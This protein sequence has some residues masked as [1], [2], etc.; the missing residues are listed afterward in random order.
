MEINLIQ[1]LL[2]ASELKK[3]YDIKLK[4]GSVVVGTV[5]FEKKQII[6]NEITIALT[7]ICDVCLHEDND[8]L[9]RLDE[10]LN[11]RIFVKVKDCE[12]IQTG[13]L[14]DVDINEIQLITSEEQITIPVSNIE[15]VSDTEIFV[16]K[17]HN[18]QNDEKEFTSE[19]EEGI[20]KYPY[21][22][23]EENLYLQEFISDEIK[24]SCIDSFEAH[25]YGKAL[26]IL[27]NCNVSE[28][29]ADAID[30]LTDYLKGVV[31]RFE[32]KGSI[33]KEEFGYCYQGGL[34]AVIEQNVDKALAF[35]RKEIEP[36][37]EHGAMAISG[38]LN[39]VIRI[40]SKELMHEVALDLERFV[41][42]IEAINGSQ[43]QAQAYRLILTIL[44]QVEDW[45][46]FNSCLIQFVGSLSTGGHIV[47]ANNAQYKYARILIENS[48]FD[49]AEYHLA[50][51]LNAGDIERALLM[52]MHCLYCHYGESG[53]DENI[54]KYLN[55]ESVNLIWNRIKENHFNGY[56]LAKEKMQF[57]EAL[58][59]NC[60]NNENVLSKNSLDNIESN[61]DE[62]H[63]NLS[64]AVAAY[65]N[66]EMEDEWEETF[67]NYRKS[68]QIPA[69]KR[70]FKNKSSQYPNNDYLKLINRRIELWQAQYGSY[71]SIGNPSS[72][73]EKGM[74]AW[75][76]EKSNNE[77]SSLFMSSI[78][79]RGG[80]SITA[81]LTFM[82]FSAVEY[83]FDKALGNLPILR[84]LVREMEKKVKIT[85]YEKIYSFAVLDKDNGEA[86]SALNLLQGLYYSKSQ[87]GK[88]EYRLAGIYYS[89]EKWAK[90]K[91]H[92]EKA[93]QYS[94]NVDN[95]SRMIE[96]C[97]DCLAG[98][99][100]KAFIFEG[101][102]ASKVDVK[103]IE[104]ELQKYFDK[105]QYDEA[106]KYIKR[107]YESATD[108][109][110]IL[111]LKDSVEK[112]VDNISKY[113]SGFPKKSD[114]ASKAW[115]AW[116]LEE[117]YSKAEIYFRK[118]MDTK[119]AK[120]LSSLFDLSEMLMHIRGN[121]AGISCLKQEEKYVVTLEKTKQ[122]SFYEKMN[123]MLQK[124]DDYDEKKE[125]LE[126]LLDAYQAQKNTEKIAYT[127]YRLGIVAF[128]NED[129]NLSISFF[130]DAI[131]NEYKATLLCYQ[132]IVSAYVKDGRE[133]D[134]L[135]FVEGMLENEKILKDGNLSTFLQQTIEKL[136]SSMTTSEQDDSI[137]EEEV[138]LDFLFEPNDKLILYL[139][140]NQ[141]IKQQIDSDNG[142]P[143][144]K[145]QMYKR[146]INELKGTLLATNFHKL[147]IMENEI[148]GQ[149]PYFYSGLDWCVKLYARDAYSKRNYD[150]SVLWN[151]YMLGNAQNNSKDAEMAKE[152]SRNILKCALKDVVIK[153][154]IEVSDLISRILA[155]ENENAEYAFKLLVFTISKSFYLNNLQ[156]GEF[157]KIIEK[158]EN[159][160]FG[161][162]IARFINVPNREQIDG[163]SL[164]KYIQ[165]R[166]SSDTNYTQMLV[167]KFRSSKSFNEEYVDEL[168]KMREM[169]FVFEE[170]VNYLND[171]IQVYE[172]A[173]EIYEYPDYD[174]RIATIRT[175]QDQIYSVSNRIDDKPTY[176][177]IYYLGD[178]LDA[179]LSLLSSVSD[180]TMQE[181]APELFIT[182]PITEVENID[183]QNTISITVTNRENAAIA[184]SLF[185]SLYDSEGNSLIDNGSVELAPYLKGGASKSIELDFPTQT[186]DTFSVRVKVQY[187]NHK[188]ELC[189]CEQDESISTVSSTYEEIVGNPYVDGKALDPQKNRNVFMGRDALLEELSSSLVDDSGQ[190]VIIYGQ[191]RCGKTSIANFLKDKIKQEFMIIDFSVGSVLSASQLYNNVRT[192]F[193]LEILKTTKNSEM[194]EAEKQELL[195]LY[196]E[197]ST[198]KVPDGEAFI[199]MMRI[200]YGQYCLMHDQE[201]LII[202]DEFTH[203]YRL[204]QKGGNDRSEVT[205]FM[206]TWKK[207]SEEKLFKSLLIG[208][209]TMPYIMAAYPNQLAITDPRRVDRLDDES[210]KQ[211]IESPI[212]LSNGNTRYMEKSVE[213]I[214][215]WFYGQPYYI[216]VYC[217]KMVEHMKATH[218]NYVTNA[219]AEKV[220]NDMLMSSTISFFDNL[221][222]AGD[223]EMNSEDELKNLPTYKLLCNI[224]LLTKNSE[225]ANIA[226]IEI[227]DK[228]KLIEDLI[229]RSVIERRKGKCRIYIN[230]FKEWLN[231]Y[232]RE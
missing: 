214:A 172:K 63:S 231:I 86:M 140:N 190:C 68:G 83:G 101:E 196:S 54:S 107:V 5:Q 60:V 123:I 18:L 219:M 169:I 124:S 141:L 87:L 201:L 70:F 117:D 166:V 10:L 155:A 82:D 62:I 49:Y 153:E 163:S 200:I 41:P 76:V 189:V 188:D 90:A 199:E 139:L 30:K 195:S 105:C 7:D 65:I 147:A 225:W 222:N 85:F 133:E 208:Q 228:E 91:E 134:A 181:L 71:K 98:K 143:K 16:E 170:D 142:E 97:D 9:S 47:A 198:L 161:E 94:Y 173:L 180:T 154:D 33:Y 138:V 20:S 42:K 25:E 146:R 144:E 121:S 157:K 21:G 217:K 209:D 204:Y 207:G 174:N 210:V 100:P 12:D 149:T 192:R 35:Y 179:T 221:I 99:T 159:K 81:L 8:I 165:N 156:E 96:Y 22:G 220:K 227:K 151:I 11:E 27:L 128:G 58:V 52:M 176:F 202:I 72:D 126:R 95:V 19:V 84:P 15:Y 28:E 135:K 150:T 112:T 152:Y 122:I 191:K 89:Q 215:N 109:E 46:G 162:Q 186:S 26:E 115:R 232:G 184:T 216:S 36:W 212:L 205:A 132:Y 175:V 118:E 194:T 229:N 3:T 39:A 73:Y 197:I 2:K 92:L 14:F 55:N 102:G 183:N 23:F 160:M 56:M 131:K 230:F 75:F 168:R 211:L 79:S 125:C 37:G 74:Y 77:A 51:L 226:D 171:F 44:S 38:S 110:E 158:P 40:G 224:A 48:R 213:L 64:S 206:D 4:D 187:K 136:K 17:K 129:Y 167:N 130:N 164:I 34:A 127:Y 104:E 218:K 145:L 78:H 178:I 50:N 148:N 103:Q 119:G 66:D 120:Y 29:N 59:A 108:K 31:D 114:F 69:A 67:S 32:D 6:V 93:I 182:I 111:R 137:H 61:S 13:F 185:V 203:L 177:S 45:D 113:P 1:A 80:D 106:Y 88:T 43:S 57:V 193:M 223:I 53:I 116:H 24:Q